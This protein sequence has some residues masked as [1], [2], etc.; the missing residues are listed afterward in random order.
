MPAYDERLLIDIH[1]ALHA[2]GRVR[3]EMESIK[4]ADARGELRVLAGVDVRHLENIHQRYGSQLVLRECYGMFH[5]VKR[6][7]NKSSQRF[8]AVQD[9][10]ESV[11][12]IE[13]RPL[14]RTVHDDDVHERVR[15][16]WRTQSKINDEQTEWPLF[17]TKFSR[18][19]HQREQYPRS[20][21]NC[22][23]IPR[24]HIE[25]KVAEFFKR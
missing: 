21:S 20:I 22:F 23:L 13:Q 6:A 4:C 3:Q 24:E 16:A 14:W 11:R 19:L 8:P 9:F 7:L 5:S 2:G 17:L 18:H 12:Q 1:L 15:K 25:A 10:L